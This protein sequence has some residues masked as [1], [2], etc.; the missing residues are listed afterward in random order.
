MERYNHTMDNK[1]PDPDVLLKRVQDEQHQEKGGKLKIYLGAA[2]GVGKTYAML[3]DAIIR[4]TS[5][6]DVVVGIAESHGRQE[7]ESLLE[8]LEV[9]PRQIIDYHSNQLSEFN[10][11]GALKRNPQLI[12]VDE[13]AHTNVFW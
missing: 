12:L 13:M 5:G 11:D 1:R 10:I 2:P 7:T 9:L 4:H 6:L 3:Q 8:Q